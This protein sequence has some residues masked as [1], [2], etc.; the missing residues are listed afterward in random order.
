[1]FRECLLLSKYCRLHEIEEQ[2]G[3]KRF[4]RAAHAHAARTFYFQFYSNTVCAIMTQVIV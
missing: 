3:K 2:R 1:M 4:V